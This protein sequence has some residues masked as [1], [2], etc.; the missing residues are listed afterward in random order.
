MIKS[1]KIKGPKR[2]WVLVTLCG[3]SGII[4]GATTSQAA[5]D[6]CLTDDT[7]SSECLTQDPIEKKIEGISMGLM[8]GVSAAIGAAW[9]IKHKEN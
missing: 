8:A 5:I 7:P 1:P 2:F 6:Q 9:N 3:L 4:L